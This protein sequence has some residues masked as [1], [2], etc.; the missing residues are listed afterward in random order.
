MSYN[1]GCLVRPE[2]RLAIYLRDNMSCL[3]CDRDLTE[4]REQLSLDHLKPQSSRTET[5]NKPSNL[6]TACR[7]C[8]ISKGK[9]RWRQFATTEAIARVVKHRRRSVRRLRTIAKLAYEEAKGERNNMAQQKSL[10]SD[11]N[12]RKLHKI[13]SPETIEL[14]RPSIERLLQFVV[15]DNA[16]RESDSKQQQHLMYT[17]PPPLTQ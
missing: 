14:H 6:V 8:N 4:E 5:D 15:E 1:N 11:A 12:L 2:L 17:T 9:K 10:I 3:Y 7:T 16:Q 13:A